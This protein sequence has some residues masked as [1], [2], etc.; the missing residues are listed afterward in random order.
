MQPNRFMQFCSR[1]AGSVTN[2]IV[3]GMTN[4]I[5]QQGNNMML[6]PR[7]DIF[8]DESSIETRVNFYNN[9]NNISS[10]SNSEISNNNNNNNYYNPNNTSE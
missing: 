5:I 9:N 4:D 8:D 7:H 10:N 1:V 2:Y 6:S 3:R